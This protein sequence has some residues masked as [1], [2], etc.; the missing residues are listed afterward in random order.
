VVVSDGAR[1]SD[2]ERWRK[3]PAKPSGRNLQKAL[4]RAA[5]IGGVGVGALN[6]DAHVPHRRVVDLARYGMAAR[7][8]AL[9]RRYGFSTVDHR[10]LCSIGSNTE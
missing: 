7:A 9:R 6:L 1:Y 5:K 2:L 10:F 4:K 3:G 8:Q